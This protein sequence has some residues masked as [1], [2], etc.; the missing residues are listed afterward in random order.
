MAVTTS[1]FPNMNTF[2]HGP[3]FCVLYR[4]LRS[5]CQSQKRETLVNRYHTIC[6]EIEAKPEDYCPRNITT[7]FGNLFGNLLQCIVLKKRKLMKI[8]SSVLLIKI[9]SKKTEISLKYIKNKM[10]MYFSL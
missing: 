4:K 2:S 5:T 6:S 7:D 10:D 8:A 9:A 3:E 1:V